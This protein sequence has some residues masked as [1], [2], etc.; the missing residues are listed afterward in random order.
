M[1][2]V[3]SYLKLLSELPEP[4]NY[5]YLWQLEH[6]HSVDIIDSSSL[7]MQGN[8]LVFDLKVK[9]CFTN[10][11]IVACLLPGVKY[12]EG[13]MFCHIP[14]EHAWNSYRGHYFDVTSEKFFDRDMGSDYHAY[15]EISGD[16]AFS[17]NTRNRGIWTPGYV[18]WLEKEGKKK[19]EA[20]Q[21]DRARK[22]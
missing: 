2:E 12:C 20:Y 8:A 16:E 10:A 21:K 13:Y 6:L 3:K 22:K 1:S 5:F 4:Q 18:Y 17:H 19:I 14:I 15:L 9:Q 7:D 11:I